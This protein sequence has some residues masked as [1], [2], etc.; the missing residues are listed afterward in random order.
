MQQVRDSRKKKQSS[1][2]I[3]EVE[4]LMNSQ[5]KELVSSYGERIKLD[6]NYLK[7]VSSNRFVNFQAVLLSKKIRDK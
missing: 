1:A 6:K 4:K 3:D 5:I 2:H 7:G